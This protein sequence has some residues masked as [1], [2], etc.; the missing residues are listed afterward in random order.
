MPNFA[1]NTF[2]QVAV[3]LGLPVGLLFSSLVAY[4]LWTGWQ[5]WRTTLQR[6]LITSDKISNGAGL[7]I[8]AA[9]S[10]FGAY[11]VTQMTANSLNIHLTNQFYFWLLIAAMLAS[12]EADCKMKT[13]FA[14]QGGA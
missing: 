7:S 8:L 1:H 11:L 3:E 5:G 2:L 14:I 12:K 13:S 6:G 4:A 10:A 9:T